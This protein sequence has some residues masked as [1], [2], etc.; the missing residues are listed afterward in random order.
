MEGRR[1][2]GHRRQRWRE[3]DKDGEGKVEQGSGRDMKWSEEDRPSGPGDGWRMQRKLDGA[4]I[5]FSCSSSSSS[6]LKLI[7]VLA[8]FSDYPTAYGDFLLLKGSVR[9]PPPPPSPPPPTQ[10]PAPATYLHSR[11]CFTTESQ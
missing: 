9:H 4:L 11:R 1:G 7:K 5:I 3:M 6:F 8:W 2:G 10:M